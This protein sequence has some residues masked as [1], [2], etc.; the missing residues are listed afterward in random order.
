MWWRK[1]TN[2]VCL[3]VRLPVFLSACLSAGAASL[4][5][6]AVGGG[7][8]LIFAAPGADQH[9]V[10]SAGHQAGE[11]TLALRLHHRL[12][13]QKCV[14]VFDEHL[15]VVEVS[16]S[17]APVHLQVVVSSSVSRCWVLHLRR[18]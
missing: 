6:P 2:T 17:V 12:V 16:G 9:C 11:H 7:A 5:C 14:V 10:E 8:G 3:S 1:T 18:L 15:V 13:L 4:T